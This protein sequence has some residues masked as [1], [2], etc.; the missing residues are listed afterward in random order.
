MNSLSENLKIEYQE[1]YSHP[2]KDFLAKVNSLFD[3]DLAGTSLYR[4]ISSRIK[5]LNLHGFE[6][7]DILLEAII[8]GV[9]MI[10][11]HREPI[12]HP[13]AWL[14]VTSSHI[15]LEEV[16]KIKGHYQLSDEL[17]EQVAFSKEENQAVFL[18]DYP[19]RAL[20]AF[21][22]L[23][24]SERRIIMHKLLHGKSYREISQLP[25]YSY[26]EETVLRSKY[27]RAVKSLRRNFQELPT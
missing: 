1:Y 13:I 26:L 23:S 6:V 18:S 2:T 10:D 12:Q 19:A 14:R 4:Y 16:R 24:K 7:H 22:R 17:L 5:A 3:G 27:A 8:R 9:V 20:Q 21:Q 25:D 11:N 15:L